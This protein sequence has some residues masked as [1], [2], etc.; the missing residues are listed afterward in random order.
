MKTV[1]K[2][3]LVISG[4]IGFAGLALVVVENDPRP[5]PILTILEPGIAPVNDTTWLS[6][7]TDLEAKWTTRAYIFIKAGATNVLHGPEK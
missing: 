4:L 2:N 1:A 6:A 5:R 3:I 7:Q